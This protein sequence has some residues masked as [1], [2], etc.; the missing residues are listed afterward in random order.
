MQIMSAYS[1][2]K[3][4][5]R[6]VMRR[7]TP[8][9]R[10][11]VLSFDIDRPVVSFTF[12]DCPKS[13][14]T[15]GLRPMEK[16]GWLGTVYIAARLFGVTNHHGLHMNGADTKAVY[17][18]G[19][20]IGDHG[21]S[22]IDGNRTALPAFLSDM[23]MNQTVLSDLGLPPCKTFA[24]PFGEA[25]PKLKLS[26]ESRF[27]GMRGIQPHA[28]VG[29]ADL[30]Q[31]ASTKLYNGPD[32]DRA[33]GQIQNLKNM[34]AWLTLFTHDIQDNPSEW[35]CTPAQMKATIEAVKETGAI[36]LPVCEAIDYL[37]TRVK[38]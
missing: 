37:R 5:S 35:G 1:P 7:V 32:F 15:H 4:L 29:Q 25:S 6:K 30:N 11:R 23:D 2:A 14:I 28:M 19:H 18:S 16:E 26:L 34:P 22:H 24:Y 36:V 20:E 3:S 38:S 8:L 33:M 17:K 21:Y 27:T 10:R 31:I 9:R 13:A 12:D